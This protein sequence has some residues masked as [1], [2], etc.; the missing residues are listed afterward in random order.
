LPAEA[1]PAPTPPSGPIPPRPETLSARQPIAP[2]PQS[3]KTASQPSTHARK[4]DRQRDAP[5]L[6]F[7]AVLQ[8]VLYSPDRQLAI[9]DGRIIAIGDSVKG[10]QV[11][12]ITSTGVLLRDE[13]GRLRRLAL[14]A[15]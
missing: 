13:Q 1:A 5:P 12:E 11:V 2:P 3:E 6:P 8:T 9:V 14:G 4:V 7:E 10:A 15:P